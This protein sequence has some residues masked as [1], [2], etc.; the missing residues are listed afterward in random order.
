M[1]YCKEIKPDII[2]VSGWL[3]NGYLKVARY[4]YGKIPTILTMDNIW[5]GS[6]RQVFNMDQSIFHENKFSL[7]GCQEFNKRFLL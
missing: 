5:K 3:D 6:L 4:F 2:L 1:K 7:F